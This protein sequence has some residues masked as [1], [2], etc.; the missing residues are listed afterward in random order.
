MARLLR[1]RILAGVAAAALG[2]GSAG[3]TEMR[4]A[5]LPQACDAASLNDADG[6]RCVTDDSGTRLG[7]R[8]SQALSVG[9]IETF[10]TLSGQASNAFTPDRL[11]ASDSR[12]VGEA[13]RQH[14]L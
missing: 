5:D 13:N 8:A 1:R 9:T 14:Q 6:A 3:A 10:A 11:T 4:Q 12:R 7:F 2:A